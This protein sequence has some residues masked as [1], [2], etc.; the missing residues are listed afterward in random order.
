MDAVVFH[1]RSG[2]PLWSV[3]ASSVDSDQRKSFEW[4]HTQLV[5]QLD[6]DQVFTTYFFSYLFLCENNR[7][8][9]Q[10]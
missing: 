10:Y 4:I 5:I 3:I 9:M 2:V 6:A 7:M 1:S 8:V